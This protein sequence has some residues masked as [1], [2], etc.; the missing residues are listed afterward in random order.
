MDKL[1]KV[2]DKIILE[3]DEMGDQELQERFEASR[4]GLVGAAILDG[5]A[6]RLSET[7]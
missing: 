5:E 7:V 6:F 4:G 1:L 3:L 2:I